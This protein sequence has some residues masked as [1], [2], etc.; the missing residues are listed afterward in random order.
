MGTRFT[1]VTGFQCAEKARLRLILSLNARLGAR[2]MLQS[3]CAACV[4]EYAQPLA[5][6]ISLTSP[7]LH[8]PYLISFSD[9]PILRHVVHSLAFSGIHHVKSQSASIIQDLPPA[10][11]T[12]VS[13][14][15]IKPLQQ[16]TSCSSAVFG[17]GFYIHS[18]SVLAEATVH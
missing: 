6:F 18:A 2:M 13:A 7:V 15:V 11:W 9:G 17:V 5:A 10:L 4:P 8:T 14:N 1:K 16:L 3:I 12:W